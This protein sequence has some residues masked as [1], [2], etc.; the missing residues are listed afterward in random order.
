MNNDVIVSE[1][2]PASFLTTA[3]L[4]FFTESVPAGYP[5]PGEGYSD[6]HVQLFEL[7]VSNP[8]ETFCVRVTGDSM[9]DAKIFSGDILIVNRAIEPKDGKIVIASI[10]GELTVKRL[11]IREGTAFLYPENSRYQ[12]M[13]L[14]DFMDTVIQGV[15]VHVIHTLD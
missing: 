5:S 3:P 6:G 9:Q 14:T 11:R 10:N 4:N 12:P 15:V 2:L 1:I 13:E 8:Q 7:L